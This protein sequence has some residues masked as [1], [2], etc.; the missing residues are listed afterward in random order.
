MTENGNSAPKSPALPWAEAPIALLRSLSRVPRTN[1]G[2][3][4]RHTEQQEKHRADDGSA[5][6]P[7]KGHGQGLKNESGAGAASRP[8]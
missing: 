5:I 4:G 6:H 3:N 1:N 8:L 2:G 7:S